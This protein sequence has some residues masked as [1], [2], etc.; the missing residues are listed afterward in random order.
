M[1][2][3]SAVPVLKTLSSIFLFSHKGIRKKKK[4]RILP[5]EQHRSSVSQSRTAKR[6]NIL[7]VTTIPR[8]AP[9]VQAPTANQFS[10]KPDWNKM[11]LPSTS[12]HLPSKDTSPE[13]LFPPVKT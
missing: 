10:K 13:G 3:L 11:L 4:K 8:A 12:K 2:S 9:T 5:P 6:N 1:R 7:P